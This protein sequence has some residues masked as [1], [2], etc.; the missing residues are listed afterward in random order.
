MRR[1]EEKHVTRTEKVQV[2]PTVCDLC[3]REYREEAHDTV[4][5]SRSVG[6]PEGGTTYYFDVCPPCWDE[7]LVPMMKNPPRESEW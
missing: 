6:F 3:G 4:E 5:V 1:T 7:R 2:G